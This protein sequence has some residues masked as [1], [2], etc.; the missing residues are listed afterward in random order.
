MN[1]WNKALIAGSGAFFGNYAKL[2][3]EQK[4]KQ[5]EQA[6][7]E[8]KFLKEKALA[9]FKA[10]QGRAGQA[11]GF[12]NAKTGNPERWDLQGKG[13]MQGPPQGQMTQKSWDA[14]QKATADAAVKQEDR[15]Y[16]EKWWKKQ[17]EFKAG[18]KTTEDL[19][20][21]AERDKK[22]ETI[23]AKY[24]N[25]VMKTPVEQ[26][27]PKDV[28]FL[29]KEGIPLISE[30]KQKNGVTQTSYMEDVMKRFDV[31]KTDNPDTDDQ[32]L[33]SQAVMEVRSFYQDAGVQIKGEGDNPMASAFSHKG[34]DGKL[35]QVPGATKETPK[36]GE[37]INLNNLKPGDIKRTGKTKDGKKVIELK[38]GRQFILNG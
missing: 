19:K 15:Q 6:M 17:Q 22:F 14:Q 11:T 9:E 33:K 31:L 1:K 16:K 28:A 36:Q 20:K 35:Q 21:E 30:F 10:Q 2:S 34:P 24:P 13:I 32:E 12:V 7:L 29:K 37:A 18:Q 27:D 5:A 4:N 38:D 25:G 3:I 23:T 26:M 8:Q